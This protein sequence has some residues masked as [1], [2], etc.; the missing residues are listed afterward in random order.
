MTRKD[1]ELI[2][3]VIRDTRTDLE[4]Y[5]SAQARELT[6]D[7][8]V[9]LLALNMTTALYNTNPRFDASRFREACK[10]KARL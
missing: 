8:A 1:Y 3:K 10:A 5:R 2:A 9:D 6:S 7:E 4:A